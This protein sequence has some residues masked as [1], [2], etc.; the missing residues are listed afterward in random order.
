MTEATLTITNAVGLHARPAA[1]FYKKTRE[2]KSKITIQNL[3]REGGKEL[4]VSPF[5]LLQMGVLQ[6]HQVRLRADGDDE[7]AAIEALTQMVADN[8]GEE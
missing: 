5:N 1:M 6:G 4:P 8:F 7:Q 3:S 2:F